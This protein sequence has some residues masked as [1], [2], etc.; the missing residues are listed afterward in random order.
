MVRLR[1]LSP[2]T[3]A[4]DSPRRPSGQSSLSSFRP[5]P[6]I[7]CGCHKSPGKTL[8]SRLPR[9]GGLRRPAGDFEIRWWRGRVL[10]AGE[11]EVRGEELELFDG[12]LAVFL[13]LAD[14][15]LFLGEGDGAAG[16]MED[17]AVDVPGVVGAE[18]DGHRG[19]VLGGHL[20]RAVGGARL[21]AHPASGAELS[22]RVGYLG[23]HAGE[24][25]GGDAVR[26]HAGGTEVAG[27]GTGEPG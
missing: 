10:D 27:D 8:D 24:G 2:R 15:G 13:Y 26:R 4:R 1:R 3:P 17:L 16:D 9:C 18:P 11:E 21:G 25:A 23:A 14:G 12:P 19:D 5:L 6:L 22:R 7:Q 20:G